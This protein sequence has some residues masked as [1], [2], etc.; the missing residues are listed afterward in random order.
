MAGY[1]VNGYCYADLNAATSAFYTS[2]PLTIQS[3]DGSTNQIQ[4]VI[5]HANNTYDL[6][7]LTY[8]S[9]S[10]TSNY[11]LALPTLTLPECDSPNDPYTNFMLGNELGWAVALSIVIA[12]SIRKIRNR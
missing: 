4:Q 9:G 10:L 8:T 11:T 12:Y 7:L 2:N 5:P 3:P 6:N 1:L